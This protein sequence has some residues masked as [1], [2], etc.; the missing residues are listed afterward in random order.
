L[1]SFNVK[2][3]IIFSRHEDK[4]VSMER[5]FNDSKLLFI[6]GDVRN[7]ELLSKITI[8]VDYIIHLAALKHVYKCEQNPEEAISINIA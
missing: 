2:K 6:L 1:L 7:K 3:I 5:Q 4:Q 8:G